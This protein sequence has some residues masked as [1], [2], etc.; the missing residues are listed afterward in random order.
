MKVL[1]L[2]QTAPLQIVEIDSLLDH[3]LKNGATSALLKELALH[4]DTQGFYV[5]AWANGSFSII[6]LNLPENNLLILSNGELNALYS[7]VV[8]GR[9]G[10][11][12]DLLTTDAAK[13]WVKIGE[14][15]GGL[16]KPEEKIA[17]E[18]LG[19]LSYLG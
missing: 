11:A 17:Y 13:A 16:K 19:D 15:V 18:G 10:L 7:Y 2:S 9:G 6:N 4:L 8:L 1:Y 3:F 14:L 12:E 5:G